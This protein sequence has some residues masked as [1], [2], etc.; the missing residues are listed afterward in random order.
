[1]HN[2]WR[3]DK[4]RK[5]NIMKIIMRLGIELWQYASLTD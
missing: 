2:V 5:G 4:L 1:M 3:I